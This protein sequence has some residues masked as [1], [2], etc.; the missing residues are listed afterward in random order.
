MERPSRRRRSGNA[1]GSRARPRRSA[2]PWI[3][4]GA[5]AVLSL[6]A[7]V[8]IARHGNE[9]PP[10]PPPDAAGGAPP[11][12]RFEVGPEPLGPRIVLPVAPSAVKD[13]A[14]ARDRLYVNVHHDTAWRVMIDGTDRTPPVSQGRWHLPGSDLEALIFRR[15]QPRPTHDLPSDLV[16]V[17]RA[18]ASCPF[19]YLQEVFATLA[20][21]K[22]RVRRVLIAARRTATEELETFLPIRLAIDPAPAYRSRFAVSIGWDPASDRATFGTPDGEFQDARA[23]DPALRALASPPDCLEILPEGTVPFRHVVAALDA[24][25]RAHAGPFRLGP[26]D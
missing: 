23:L 19:A 9:D 1:S 14:D 15:A 18:D 8:A 26:F 3:A 20:A 21:R 25:T 11:P 2:G 6:V 16:V 17:L 12:I 22:I 13:P 7:I 10:A 4:I 5:T 24:C